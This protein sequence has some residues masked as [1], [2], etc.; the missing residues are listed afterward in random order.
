MA[1]S[2]HGGAAIVVYGVHENA[3]QTRYNG[4][5]MALWRPPVPAR[6]CNRAYRVQRTG[7]L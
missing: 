1:A 4:G 5:A 7:A 3:A 6:L 2:L